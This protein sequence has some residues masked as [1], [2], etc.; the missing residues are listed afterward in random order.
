[1][2]GIVLF[3][4]IVKRSMKSFTTTLILL[5]GL[6]WKSLA[7]NIDESC[8]C[9]KNNLILA[10]DEAIAVLGWSSSVAYACAVLDRKDC[11]DTRKAGNLLKALFG[12]ASGTT[13]SKIGGIFMSYV[14]C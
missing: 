10:V 2:T 8:N 7:Y 13:Y 9:V 12:D 14:I 1:L 4:S 5:L 3:I 11:E 6:A